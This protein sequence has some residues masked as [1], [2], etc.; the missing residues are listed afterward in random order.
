MASFQKVRGSEAMTRSVVVAS[1]RVR[2][3]RSL[4]PFHSGVWGKVD[5]HFMPRSSRKFLN[6]DD[7]YSP[8]PSVRRKRVL[9]SERFSC[10]IRNF[11][12]AANV[13]FLC[14]RKSSSVQPE[15]PSMKVANHLA[16]VARDAVDMGPDMSL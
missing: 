16:C 2:F 5:S 14:C 4:F 10:I 15:Y 7:V 1:W 3:L 13:S 6:S 11:L 8:P 9:A 12:N